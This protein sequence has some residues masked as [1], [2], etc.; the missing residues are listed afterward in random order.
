MCDLVC[1]SSR[2]SGM[3]TVCSQYVWKSVCHHKKILHWFRFCSLCCCIRNSK[4]QKKI[5]VRQSYVES[6]YCIT[7]ILKLSPQLKHRRLYNSY[8]SFI[9]WKW[10]GEDYSATLLL[11]THKELGLWLLKLER[12]MTMFVFLHTNYFKSKQN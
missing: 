7:W 8:E 11:C 12:L 5:I 2:L 6:R 3:N 10:K 1:I 9:I 4:M